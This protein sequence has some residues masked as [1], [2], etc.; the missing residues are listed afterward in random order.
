MMVDQMMMP[1]PVA[2]AQHESGS[3]LVVTWWS[4]PD[5]LRFP[6]GVRDSELGFDCSM[7]RIDGTIRC[8][9]QLFGIVHYGDPECRL[10]VVQLSGT[11]SNTLLTENNGYATGILDAVGGEYAVY[12]LRDPVTVSVFTLS[13]GECIELSELSNTFA[14]RAVDAASL[15]SLEIVL[16]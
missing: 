1:V 16:D 10:P 3:R 13:S 8:V 15:A 5:G 7:V 11:G 6:R 2:A 4:S 12:E 14:T 9:P